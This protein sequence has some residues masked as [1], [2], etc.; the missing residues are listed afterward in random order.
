VTWLIITLSCFGAYALIVVSLSFVALSHQASHGDDAK[1]RTIQGRWLG[2]NNDNKMGGRR[3]D[4]NI[5][6]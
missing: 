2:N 1:T 4:M 5:S 3:N 6:P